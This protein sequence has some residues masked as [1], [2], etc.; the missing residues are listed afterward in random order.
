MATMDRSGAGAFPGVASESTTVEPPGNDSAELMLKRMVNGR[1]DV[2]HQWLTER[3]KLLL[4]SGCVQT[5]KYQ[6][7]FHSDYGPEGQDKDEN[8]DYALVWRAAEVAGTP[9]ERVV[10]AMADG[11]TGSFRSELASR[12][13]CTVA[14]R[15]IAEGVGCEGRRELLQ[16][17]IADS[18]KALQDLKE[19]LLR[20][21]GSSCPAGL[22]LP[23]WRYILRRGLLFQ[24]TLTVAL[25]DQG[26]LQVAIVG[27]G[28]MLSRMYEPQEDHVDAQCDLGTQ[29][30]HAIG[31]FESCSTDVDSF[32]ERRLD[33][34]RFLYA[35]FTDGIG[36]A[37]ETAPLKLLE[38]L[39]SD[40]MRGVDN[41]AKDYIERVKSG[42]STNDNLTLAVVRSC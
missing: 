3:G 31:P 18:A 5:G 24:T 36:R 6:L 41:S 2:H 40:A 4:E 37:L 19:E 17:A 20:D 22:F 15:T 13:A 38:D 39:D 32:T 10:L 42:Q 30:V 23:T 7:S 34:G 21:P 8:Q 27:D 26:L 28:G 33:A 29:E 14:L 11:L 16:R 12:L 35:L 25:L 1:I 9:S